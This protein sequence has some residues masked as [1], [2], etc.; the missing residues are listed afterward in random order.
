MRKIS[1]FQLA[2]T[3][4]SKVVLG[5]NQSKTLEYREKNQIFTAGYEYTAQSFHKGSSRP[6][7]MRILGIFRPLLP[8]GQP[9]ATSDTYV[10][11]QNYDYTLNRFRGPFCGGSSAN[12]VRTSTP[13]DY[14]ISTIDN[15][16]K[17]FGDLF[18]GVDGSVSGTFTPP[19]INYVSSYSSNFANTGT[20]NIQAKAGHA[21]GNFK[22]QGGNEI[23]FH[24]FL[25]VTGYSGTWALY[26]IKSGGTTKTFDAIANTRTDFKSGTW[27]YVTP[28]SGKSVNEWR[29]MPLCTKQV[30]ALY[31][32]SLNNVNGGL[33][34]NEIR[35]AGQQPPAGVDV[36]SGLSPINIYSESDTSGWSD[37]FFLS[38]TGLRLYTDEQGTEPLPSGYYASPNFYAYYDASTYNFSGMTAMDT[39][40]GGGPTFNG[41]TYEFVGPYG[42][43]EDACSLNGRAE[44]NF[45]VVDTVQYAEPGQ[46]AI[47]YSD[48]TGTSVIGWMAP[49][50]WY[51]VVGLGK[52]VMIDEF[53]AIAAESRCR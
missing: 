38:Q 13:L 2:T 9:N 28:I 1:N 24:G 5:A 20:L 49:Y 25:T 6:P 37:S 45:G 40:G 27:P 41:A 21:S 50:M 4:T 26:S 42:G 18:S 47:L 12:G 51:N 15:F 32:F 7:K 23:Y 48:M 53:G 30:A 34:T 36:Y 35:N 44:S 17:N 33:G 10:I 3:F 8:S 39:G 52:S 22:L 31:Y 19:A 43:P 14:F 11:F 29:Y 46:G 16:G